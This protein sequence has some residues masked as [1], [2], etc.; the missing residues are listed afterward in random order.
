VRANGQAAGVVVCIPDLNPFMKAIGGEYGWR[1]PFEFVKHR[2]SRKRAVI[3]YYS[4]AAAHQGRGLN[5]AMLYRVLTNLREAG[6][7]TLG[8]T[9]IADVNGASLRQMEKLG[10]RRLHRLHLFRKAIA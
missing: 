2:L 5:T 10:A 6:Y 3:I 8:V 1:A 7:E 4:T 9:W